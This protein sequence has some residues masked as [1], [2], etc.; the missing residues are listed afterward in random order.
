MPPG[1]PYNSFVVPYR[2]RVD[3]FTSSAGLETAPALHLLSHTHSDHI[4]GL[5][6]KSFGYTVICS[7]DAKEMLLR[8]EVY[9]ERSLREHEYR[10]EATR[11]YSHLKVD[12]LVYP[13]GSM[14]YTGARDLLKP[15]PLNTP[16]KIELTNDEWVTVTLFDANHCPGAVMFLIEGEH[17]AV[18]HTGDFRAEPWFLEAITHNPFLQP[19]LASVDNL[20]GDS[21]LDVIY[22]DTASVMSSAPVPTKA[23]ATHGLV[24][25]MKLLPSTTYFFINSWTWGYEDALKAISRAFRSKIHFDRYKHNIYTNIS[26]PVLRSIGTRDDGATRFH[27]CE[28]FDRCDYVAVA[29]HHHETTSLSLKSKRVIY[30]NPVTM[31]AER[32]GIY[33]Q[34][35]KLAIA[36]GELVTNLLVPLSRHSPLPELQ[37]FVSLFRPR[38]V[39]PNT[40]IPAFRGLDWKAIDRMFSDCLCKPPP[41]EDLDSEAMDLRVDDALGD[42]EDAALLN[43]VGGD[44]VRGVAEKWAESGSLRRKLEILRS[45]LGGRE[46]RAIDRI[47][48]PAAPPVPGYAHARGLDS[49]D[50]ES[51]DDD[52]RGRTAHL[53]F[54]GLA[55]IEGSPAAWGVRASSSPATP[56]TGGARAPFLTPTSSPLRG[57]WRPPHRDK[58]KKRQRDSESQSQ[59]PPS[60]TPPRAAKRTKLGD[61]LGS[62]FSSAAWFATSSPP[63]PLLSVENTLLCASQS[64][65]P[66]VPWDGCTTGS[67]P[68]PHLPRAPAALVHTPP[69]RPRILRSPAGG[70]Y[71]VYEILPASSPLHA[72][73][74][75]PQGPDPAEVVSAGVT[76]DFAAIDAERARLAQRLKL[77]DRLLRAAHPG[78]VIPGFAAKRRKL[79]HRAFVLDTKAAFLRAAAQAPVEMAGLSFETVYDAGEPREKPY[80][81]DSALRARIEEALKRGAQPMAPPLMSARSQSH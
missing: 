68:P 18:L 74:E 65:L 67:S 41:L 66:S 1:S 69:S 37:A 80:A 49:E 62:P 25:L 3:E 2:I 44:S 32:W 22:L 33:L 59:C 35:S 79:E 7:H 15:L 24:E 29:D 13:D 58:G 76:L 73:P 48:L 75:Q 28:R 16:T 60:E 56:A 63:N 45:W 14:Y 23:Q 11:T 55:G 36:R 43:V 8:H 52:E 31:N 42:M 51:D 78:C 53:L 26:D 27:A 47:L 4:T 54:A 70:H 34:E 20:P 61:S 50:E 64:R 38:K 81:A 10:A 12:P 57:A 21:T 19:Y 77:Q 46:R 71:T 6:A 5:Q 72:E 30:V 39:V 17:G 40:L 9:A